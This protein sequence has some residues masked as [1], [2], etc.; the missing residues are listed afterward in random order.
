M[1]ETLKVYKKQQFFS[2]DFPFAMLHTRNHSDYFNL[3]RRFLR[4]F[5]KITY[6]VRGGGNLVIGNV[7][8][9]IKPQSLIVIHP[10]AQ[11]TWDMKDDNEMEVYNIVFDRTIIENTLSDVY[12]AYQFMRIFSDDYHQEDEFPLFM[13]KA[14]DREIALLHCM[15]EEFE[16]AYPNRKQMIRLKLG[17]L[18]LLMLRQINDFGY[19]NPEWIINFVDDNIKRHFQCK[20]QISNLAAQI[21][22]SPEHLSRLYHRKTGCRIV[23]K[24]KKMRLEYAA[25]QL[26]SSRLPITEICYK[27]GFNDMSYFCRSFLAEFRV[28]PKNYRDKIGQN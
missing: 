25:E 14:G 26:H 11:T 15:Y 13:L 1:E 5:W 19:H 4:E 23:E 8:Y 27:S 7:F 2:K 9:P 21:G 17:E 3:S 6:V 10:D 12:D 20:I 22:V 28:T 24:I 16:S 18:L